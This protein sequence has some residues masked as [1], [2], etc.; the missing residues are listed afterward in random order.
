M[1]FSPLYS[2]SSGN[3]SLVSAGGVNVLVD[4]GMTGKAVETALMQVGISPRELDAI[5]VTH[6]HID[7]IKGV[8][9]LS[10]RY[11][12]PVYANEGTWKAMAEQ[13]GGVGFGNVRTFITGQDFFIGDINITPFS[14]SHDAAEPVGYTFFHKGSELVYMT[15]TGCVGDSLRELA[16]RADLLFIE[17]NHDVGLLKCGPYPYQLKK[18]ILS[19]KGHLSNDACGELLTKLYTCGVRRAILAHLSHENNTEQIAYSTVREALTAEG[20]A[21]KDYF[22]AVAHRDRVTGVFEL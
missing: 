6:E 4:A 7:H 15:D 17:A 19:D 18:R 10:R 21:E 12:L 14:T 5:V 13:V 22:L 20:V 2:G 16:Q 8:G 1:L 9:I 3:C 11:N